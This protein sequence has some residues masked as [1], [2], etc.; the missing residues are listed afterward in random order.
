MSTA[1]DAAGRLVIPKAVRDAAGIQPGMPLEVC[2]R[3]GRIEIEPTPLDVS[4]RS[5]GGVA[6]AS[7]DGPV[8]MLS[9]DTVSAMRDRL[10]NERG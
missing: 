2:F 1:I 8:P 7:P 3:D 5:V 9:A 10:R 6:V 4:I